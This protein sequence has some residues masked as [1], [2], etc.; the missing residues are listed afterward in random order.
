M[1]RWVKPKIACDDHLQL[2]NIGNPKH[3]QMKATKQTLFSM[4]NSRYIWQ[5]VFFFVTL[6]PEITLLINIYKSHFQ[7]K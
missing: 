2:T 5:D 1:P 3:F 6:Q 4:A 7:E